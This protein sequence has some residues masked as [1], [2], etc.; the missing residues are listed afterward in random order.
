M[1]RKCYEKFYLTEDILM[2]HAASSMERFIRDSFDKGSRVLIVAGVGNNGA[3]GVA[4]ARLLNRDFRVRVY[5]PFGIK[6]SMAKLQLE[7]A[8]SVGVQFVKDIKKADIVVDG[9]IWAG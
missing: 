6:S 2:E 8:K 4:L 7:R 3:D 9:S 5:I 1:D